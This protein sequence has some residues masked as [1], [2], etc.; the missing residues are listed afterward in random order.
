[1]SRAGAL[2]YCGGCSPRCRQPWGKKKNMAVLLAA[3]FEGGFLP[4]PASLE[5]GDAGF[6]GYKRQALF[7]ERRRK[8][9]NGEEVFPPFTRTFPAFVRSCWWGRVTGQRDLFGVCPAGISPI[10]PGDG[11]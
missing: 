9:Q 5:S 8:I 2:S 7:G 10:S 3:S 1:M 4:V 11:D 6:A